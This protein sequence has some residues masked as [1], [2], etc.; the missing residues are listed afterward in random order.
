M[1][2]LMIVGVLCSNRIPG[3]IMRNRKF[4]P[5][6]IK[7]CPEY[8]PFKILHLVVEKNFKRDGNGNSP[9]VLSGFL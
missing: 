2:G 1:F 5:A 7:I 4:I 9:D 3:N 6:L 8:F